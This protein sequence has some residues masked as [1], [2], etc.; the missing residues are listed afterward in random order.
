MN[1]MK[2]FV[3]RILKNKVFWCCVLCVTALS[4]TAVCYAN[5]SGK[6][7]SF[8]DLFFE[9]QMRQIFLENDITFE[10]LITN[11]ISIFM[12]MFMPILVIF[13]FLNV[14]WNEKM[15]N[16][17]LFRQARIGVRKY[18][19][20]SMAEAVL[21]S[22]LLAVLGRFL[23]EGILFV[24]FTSM[25]K[26]P[27]LFFTALLKNRYI[28]LCMPFIL[29][30]LYDLLL[31]NR[32]IAIWETTGIL[33]YPWKQYLVTAGVWMVAAALVLMIGCYC[34]IKRRFLRGTW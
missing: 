15:T 28:I 13:P 27:V 1:W 17:Y 5:E 31:R 12:A 2:S 26:T 19:V 20:G 10:S 34:L 33:Y 7:Y 16:N 21:S 32:N 18:I 6:E 23:Y 8:W 14:F 22:G 11:P 24:I 9:G 3:E 25:G 30:Y 29:I 4:F